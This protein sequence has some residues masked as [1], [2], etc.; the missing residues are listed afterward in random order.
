MILYPAIDLKD[1]QCVRLLRGDMN[2]ATTFSH[3]P[4]AQAKQFA[5]QGFSW[6]HVVDLNG[7]FEGK[8]VNASAVSAIV[9]AVDVP[10][11]LGGGIRS[12]AHIEQWLKAGVARIIIGTQAVKQ[13][14][15]VVDACKNFPGRVAVGI[16]A[17]GG[18]VA[19]QGWGEV[20]SMHAIDVALRF[21]DAGVCA[22]I[23]TDINRDGAMQGPN[24][25]ETV[26]LAERIHTPVILSGGI[27]SLH[28]LI[29]LKAFT[30]KGI[31]GAIIGRAM[32]EGAIDPA[33]ALKAVA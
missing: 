6:I 5:D 31:S 8:P 23:Y 13:P 12:M 25:A 29:A 3:A 26:A 21:E 2:A 4:D 16:D 28:D 9:E 24:I 18:M 15:L 33:A 27:S 7:A 10:V 30:D 32:Y 14:Q 11:Q 1:G 20:S 22:I 17:I 19:V